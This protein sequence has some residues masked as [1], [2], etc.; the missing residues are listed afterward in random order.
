MNLGAVP[1]LKELK[2]ASAKNEAAA[3]TEY[4]GVLV[5]EINACIERSPNANGWA[6]RM[7]LTIRTREAA[8]AEAVIDRYRDSGQYDAWYEPRNTYEIQKTQIPAMIC[9]CPKGISRQEAIPAMM[10]QL[11]PGR[12]GYF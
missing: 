4:V 5:R 2:A 9:L 12:R 3:L 6:V 7:P 8:A 11:H 1:N 10:K